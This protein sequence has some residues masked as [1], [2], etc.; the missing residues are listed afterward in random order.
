MRRHR[1]LIVWLCLFALVWCQVAMSAQACLGPTGA[2]TTDCHG[3]VA[4]QNGSDADPADCPVHDVTPD[5][6]KLPVFAPLPG[7]VAHLPMLDLR[8][9]RWVHTG[10]QPGARAG[11]HL[12]TL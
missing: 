3:I 10:G 5:L 12:A 7:H 11:P 1:P 2:A 8:P 4:D 9:V 6:G